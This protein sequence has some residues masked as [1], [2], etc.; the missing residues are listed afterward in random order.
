[1]WY[2]KIDVNSDVLDYHVSRDMA[3]P[4]IQTNRYFICGGF[5]MHRQKGHSNP[6]PRLR[7]ST[8][9]ESRKSKSVYKQPRTDLKKSGKTC[10]VH[11]KYAPIILFDRLRVIRMIVYKYKAGC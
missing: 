10:D 3:T 1:M 9:N 8:I 4:M 5:D 7:K 11:V 2:E 6:V